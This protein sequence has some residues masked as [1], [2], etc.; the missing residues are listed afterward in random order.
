MFKKLRQAERKQHKLHQKSKT[1][2]PRIS[3]ASI[4]YTSRI[5]HEALGRKRYF[6]ILY[7]VYN[8]IIPSVTAVLAGAA[9]TQIVSAITTHDVG[10]FLVIAAILM[11][12]QLTDT[13]LREVNAWF[14][15]SNWQEVYIYVS[16]KM[17]A[18]Y[19]QIPL[20]KRE[21]KEFAD[22]FER[23]EDF[24]DDISS[25]SRNLIS[26]ATSV[27]SL[28]SVL[29]ATLTVSP[30]VTIVVVVAAI[31]YSIL[32]LKLAAKQR[33][34]WREYT[35]DRRIAWYI[36]DKITD[37]DSA[38]EIELNGLSRHLIQQMVK[39]RR[40]AQEQDIAD[41]RRFFWP[42]IA[43]RGIDDLVSYAVL[44]FVA[45]EIIWG[46]LAIGQFLTVR[47][48]L[49]QLN[50]NINTLFS[51]IA[52]A[53]QSL[54]NATDFM[55]FMNEPTY[56]DGNIKINS[57]P[58]IEF[59]HVS[60]SYPN[61]TQKAI[62]DVSFTLSAGDSLAIV[63]QNG[64][65]KTTLIK[66]LIG[67]YTPDGGEILVDGQPLSQIDRQSYLAQIG[68]LFQEYTQYDFATLGENVWFGDVKKPYN[69]TAIMHALSMVGLDQ[70]VS[71][72]EKG[73]DQVMS[74]DLDVK[75]TASLSGGQWQRLCIARAFFRA[76]NVLILDEPTSAVDAKSEY[77]IFKNIL[78]TQ[79]GKSTLIIS[80][81]FSTVRKAEHIMVLDHGKMI[82]YGTHQELIDEN[83]LYK[84][85]F[86][87]QAEGYH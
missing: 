32:S 82:E 29:I 62:N 85:M 13:V 55:D 26:I 48:L 14:A 57:T 19:I 64:A 40:R 65:G 7:Q 75:N 43:T 27:I 70:M 1:N 87:L 2:A 15:E 6:T 35:K 36:R 49:A 86:E 79:A 37:S 69:K 52:E 56:V 61:A 30:L 23:V 68:A 20:T 73:L 54:V 21:S 53:S 39:A 22:R 5:Y 28:V 59:R 10:P 18:K 67:A 76:P 78:Q 31:P 45:F 12:I 72:Y 44:I 24:G 4:L 63:G 83:K 60:Y 41:Q 81:R 11:L 38:L 47:N 16:E 3:L 51:S 9:V 25:V 66:L 34:N 74:K 58:T 17:A 42:N 84:E 33:R 50:N 80:H 71:K 8:S 77:E 46:K